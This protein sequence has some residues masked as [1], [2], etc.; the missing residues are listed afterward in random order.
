MVNSHLVD[1]ATFRYFVASIDKC[2]TVVFSFF[3]KR[4]HEVTSSLY[5]EH[6]VLFSYCSQCWHSSTS[7]F[8]HFFHKRFY[9]DSVHHFLSFGIIW[10]WTT[11]KNPWLSSIYYHGQIDVFFLNLS[12]SCQWILLHILGT[13][14]CRKTIE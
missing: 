12:L 7:S 13:L 9:C 6:F 2:M 8:F 3:K 5:L 1:I 14:C 10:T 4:L 11:W